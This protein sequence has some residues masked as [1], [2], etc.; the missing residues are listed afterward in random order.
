MAETIQHLM[1]KLLL[2]LLSLWVKP[3][4]IPSEPASLLDPA[5]PVLY[6]LEIGGIADRTVLALACSRHDLPDPAARLHYGTL[7]ESSSVDVLQRRQ[8]L[9]FR[10]HRNVQ[11]RRLGRLITAGLD[12]RA[13]ELQ[14]VPVS[15]YW[16]RAPD[17]ELSVWRLWFTE[18]W[19]I[20]GRT[21]KLLTTILHGRDTL[22]SFSEPLSFLALKDSEETTEV[23]QR[24]LSRILRV[25]FRQRRIASLGPDQSHR[26]MLI[27]HVLADTSVRQ[28]ILAHSTNGSEERARQQ[29]EKYAFE[30]AAD[31]SYP[32]IRIFQRLLTRLW[33]ELYDGVEVAGIHRLKHV[34]DGHELIY[35]PCH[36]S[37]I[38][39]LLL[40]YILYTQG[41]SLPHIAAGI[42]LNLPVVGGLLRRGGAF[43]LRRSFAGK[44]LY[45]AVFNAYLKEILQ[46][47]HALEYFV[48]G[49]RSRTGR[50]L[51]AKGGMLAM[52]VSAYLQEPRTPVMFIP[53]YLGYERLLEGRAFTSELAGGRKQKETVFALLKSLRTLRENYGQVYV[54]FGEPIAL[55]HLLDEHQP[56]WRELPVFHDRPAWLKPVVDQLG[57]DIMQRINEAACVTPISLLAITMLATPRGCISRDELLQQIDMYHALLRG[58]HA[59]T[60]VV[61]PQVDANALIEH[62]IRLGFIETRHDS[63]GPMIRLRPGQAAAMTYFRNNI[64]HLL[65]LPALIAAT[66]NNRR[67]RTDEQLRYL[68]N[69]S[70]PFLQRELLQNT[71]LGSAAVDQALT[72]L[73][74]ASLLGKSDN[75]WHRAS[76]GSLHA[77]SLMRLAQVVMPALERN[78]LCASL[79]ARAPEGRI[80]GDVLAHRNQLSAERLASTQGQDST[81]LF[82]RHL[83][84]SFVT[85]LI[86][87]GFVLRDGDMLI[88][89]ASMLEVENE[90]R[91]L[92]GEQVRHAIISAALAASNA[93]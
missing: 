14:I 37:H 80:S 9:V 76:A 30:I 51:P 39:Y 73:E 41:Y 82:D 45:A 72:A 46:R 93:S 66:F 52:T 12:S 69:L 36:R 27:N 17:K 77:V 34:A 31:V 61:V 43:F 19:Q 15:V 1:Q 86:R 38:D 84:A 21:R 23:L 29:A 91:T 74:Q 10:K 75:R 49:G 7:S 64:L 20:A 90:A 6:V 87:Q 44:P 5:I 13:G 88:P 59:D 70:Y 28:A 60:L 33:N 35:V 26:R 62:G 18:N 11:S 40:S 16:G 67:S 89:Q 55:S 57:R 63:I 32:T 71:E 85:E 92:L 2:R 56:G 79:L 53:V 65:T 22:L 42:N 25:H 50:L 3:Q 78:Y 24:K 58:A 54:N 83:H 8:G 48:E 81:E 4:V 47:G 68:V